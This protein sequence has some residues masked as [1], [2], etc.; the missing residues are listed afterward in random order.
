MVRV[1]KNL[2]H[3][4]AVRFGTV[5]NS[6]IATTPIRNSLFISFIT[7]T[8]CYRSRHLDRHEAQMRRRK[9]VRG[10]LLVALGAASAWVIIESARALTMF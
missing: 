8:G 1:F 7:E 4:P 2:F 6:R 9:L 5:D 3:R 10:A